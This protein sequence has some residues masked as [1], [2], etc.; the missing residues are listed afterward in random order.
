MIDRR[1]LKSAFSTITPQQ[2]ELEA[3]DQESANVVS[4]DIHHI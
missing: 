2:N 1:N 3:R 4:T